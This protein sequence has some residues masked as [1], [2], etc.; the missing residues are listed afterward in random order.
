MGNI[1]FFMGH[2]YMLFHTFH[3]KYLAIHPKTLTFAIEIAQM[4]IFNSNGLVA[5]LVRATDS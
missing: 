3:Q 2:V 5:Q 4:V 1:Y